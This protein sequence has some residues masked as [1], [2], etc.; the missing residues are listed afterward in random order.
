MKVALVH[1]YLNQYGGAER[2]LETLME[3]FPSAPIYTLLYDKK[4]TLGRFEGR[5]ART[6]FLDSGFVRRNHRAFLP[7]MPTAIK[8]ITVDGDYD[9]IISDSAGYGKGIRHRHGHGQRYCYG[10]CERTRHISYCH[11]PLRY[12]WET[13]DYVRMKFGSKLGALVTAVVSPVAWYLRRWDYQAGQRPDIM[14]ANSNFIAQKIKTNYNRKAQVIYP[15]VDTNLFY[16]DGSKSAE[17]YY[18]AVG[19]LQHYKRFDLIIE[20]FKK[21]EKPLLIV[22]DGPEEGALKNLA[23]G[24][25]NIIFIPFVSEE[26]ELRKLYHNARAL[27]FAHTEDFG[28][29]PAE[30]QACGLPVVAFARGGALEI[31]KDGITGVLFQNQTLESFLGAIKSFEKKAFDRNKISASSQRFSKENFK[32]EFQKLI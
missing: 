4:K 20:A 16:Y 7:I 26:E 32:K 5:I 19:R 22:G 10:Y 21:L 30:A 3:I 11:T 15:P 8:T 18:L 29:V 12:A 2:V 13:G 6:S 14:L 23:R 27:I 9:L 24:Y 28:L 31:V 25:S 17:S 1:D